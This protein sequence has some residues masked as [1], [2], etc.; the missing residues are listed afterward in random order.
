MPMPSPEPEPMEVQSL[1]VGMTTQYPGQQ[2]A[3]NPAA[4]FP[5][6]STYSHAP[7]PRERPPM[8]RAPTSPE[9]YEPVE[10]RFA[11]AMPTQ[12]RPQ[13]VPRRTAQPNQRSQSQGQRYPPPLQSK[14]NGHYDR[15]P[16]NPRPAYPQGQTYM[17]LQPAQAPAS[18]DNQ[19]V[20][21]VDNKPRSPT[22]PDPR[23]NA[24][25]QS[26]Y[27]PLQPTPPATEGDQYMT[28]V[29]ERPRPQPRPRAAPRRQPPQSQMPHHYMTLEGELP[30]HSDRH[31][32]PSSGNHSQSP[33]DTQRNYVMPDLPEL[34]TVTIDDH[35]YVDLDGTGRSTTS[36]ID[37]RNY[38]DPNPGPMV[39]SRNYVPSDSNPLIAQGN[40]VDPNPAGPLVDQ[41]NYVIPDSGPYSPVDEQNYIHPGAIDSQPQPRPRE[42]AVP[43][44]PSPRPRVGKPRTNSGTASSAQDFKFDKMM[45]TFSPSQVEM[46]VQMLQKVQLQTQTQKDV[47]AAWALPTDVKDNGSPSRPLYDSRAPGA[48]PQYELDEDHTRQRNLR[49]FGCGRTRGLAKSALQRSFPKCIRRLEAPLTSQRCC[50]WRHLYGLRACLLGNVDALSG[51]KRLK[52]SC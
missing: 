51:P 7:R 36:A 30:A 38:I 50:M 16:P 14:S 9:V 26:Q 22:Q 41:R 44:P 49:K 37:E 8:S 32:H 27:M 35:E 5:K 31:T 42:A 3:A 29:G 13:P 4:A 15:P 45:E 11:A 20:V 18:E 19:Y 34:A 47:E 39:D 17:P 33:L 6:R 1:P 46:L 21:I 10:G 25:S 24:E 23:T 2:N 40:Y 52:I 12:Y 43:T 28:L 48:V